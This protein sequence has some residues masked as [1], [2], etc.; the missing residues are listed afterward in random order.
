MR[1]LSIAFLL[2]YAANGATLVSNV[3][4][5]GVTNCNWP[6]QNC[7]VATVGEEFTILDPWL[8]TRIKTYQNDGSNHTGAEPGAVGFIDLDTS[9]IFSWSP[10]VSSTDIEWV[11]FPNAV[12]PAGNYRVWSSD[13][14]SW[15]YNSATGY[16]DEGRTQH[17]GMAEAYGNPMPTPEPVSVALVGAGVLMLAALRR[18]T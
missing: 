1:Y 10:D 5:S 13:P 11:A 2:A 3:N 8:I 7:Q 4:V 14:A 6:G 12:L 9:S 18:K 15:S 16:A 17:I